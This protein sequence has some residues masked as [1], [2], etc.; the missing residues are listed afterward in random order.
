MGDFVTK[1]VFDWVLY[2]NPKMVKAVKLVG[3]L[4][5]DIAGHK[6]GVTEEEAKEELRKQVADGWKDI[7]KGLRRPIIVPRL[8]LVRF[9][10]FARAMH[11]AYKDEIDLYT[12]AG[13]KFK[14]HATSLYANPL[15]V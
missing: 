4:L 10:N 15:S 12:H 14:K 8:L 2:G 6:Y 7:N 9:L 5:D 13:T 1:D 3:R 11:V